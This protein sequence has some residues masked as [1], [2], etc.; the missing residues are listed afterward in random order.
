LRDAPDQDSRRRIA[1]SKQIYRFFKTHSDT[2]FKIGGNKQRNFR[3]FLHPVDEMDGFINAAD[4][5]TMPPTLF[6]TPGVEFE[7]SGWLDSGNAR[8]A[9][10][11]SCPIFSSASF[12]QLLSA[13]L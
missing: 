11:T 6:S 13:H 4:K 7:V 3:G 12:F 2:G 10:V 8:D 5:T 9:D 1:I